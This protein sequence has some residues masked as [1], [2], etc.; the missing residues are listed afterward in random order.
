MIRKITISLVAIAAVAVTA[1]PTDVSAR[2][3]GGYSGSYR[4]GYSGSYRSGYSGSYR[5]GYSGSYRS[6]YS[7]SYR[8]G[9]YG[10]YPYVSA[11]GDSCWRWQETPLGLR[12][13]WVCDDGY[14]YY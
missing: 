5:S 3:R 2:D 7:G 11:Y 8:G 12:R 4:S 14:S 9:Y 13:V 6:G 10:G 1:L